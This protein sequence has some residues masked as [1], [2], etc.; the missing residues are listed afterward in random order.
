VARQHDP[1]KLSARVDGAVREVDVV[2]VA[3]HTYRITIDGVEHAVDARTLSPGSFS[4]LIDQRSVACD[5]RSDGEKHRVDLAGRTI[6]VKLIDTLRHGGVAVEA[7]NAGGPQEIRAMMPGKIVTVLVSVGDTV[8]KGTGVLVVEAMKMENEV[9][10]AGP[11]VVKEVLVQPG[12]A[13]EA[14]EVLA[15]LE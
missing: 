12:Q 3:P 13:V 9:K 4:L 1:L 2:E 5:V 15:R 7:E 10:S 11:G 6:E 14:G 8:E